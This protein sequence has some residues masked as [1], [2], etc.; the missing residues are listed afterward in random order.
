M[1]DLDPVTAEFEAHRAYLF[2]IAY[3]LLGTVSD[4]E[5]MVQETYVRWRQAPDERLLLGPEVLPGEPLH[6]AD[7]RARGRVP[8]PQRPASGKRGE[9]KGKRRT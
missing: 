8:E 9:R 7:D 4:A 6:H 2:S 1:V 3:R 5:D